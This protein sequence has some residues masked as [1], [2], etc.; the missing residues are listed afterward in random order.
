VVVDI[1]HED[2]VLLYQIMNHRNIIL[3][4]VEVTER[5]AFY[6]DECR[7]CIFYLLKVAANLMNSFILKV[8][9]QRI[10]CVPMGINCA[11]QVWR[12]F[13]ESPLH[14]KLVAKL[15]ED[16]NQINQ[17][18]DPYLNELI[19][20]LSENYKEKLPVLQILISKDHL[21]DFKSLFVE[22]LQ[23]KIS[24][25]ALRADFEGNNDIRKN[26]L[27]IAYELF[28]CSEVESLNF[29]SF[30]LDAYKTKRD[31]L[32]DADVK[33]CLDRKNYRIFMK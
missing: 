3:F 33:I 24:H 18:M 11:E 13:T 1:G 17:T 19:T 16:L 32:S 25:F 15:K 10:N 27:L 21:I 29:N 5:L 14:G 7:F 31:T 4:L 20:F 22:E 6:V 30:S 8:L 28:L 2:E 23:E 9:E 12:R 26:Y